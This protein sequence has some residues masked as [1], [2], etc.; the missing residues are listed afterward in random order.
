MTAV[1]CPVCQTHSFSHSFTQGTCHVL[2]T[3]DTATYGLVKI[4]ALWSWH[5]QGRRVVEG[6]GED[7]T[8]KQMVLV[9]QVEVRTREKTRHAKGRTR[10]RWWGRSISDSQ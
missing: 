10:Q 6:W 4:P 7:S 5:A 1:T 8:T 3:G 2:S 9:C